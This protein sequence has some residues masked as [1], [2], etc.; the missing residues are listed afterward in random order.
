MSPDCVQ[1]VS[2]ALVTMEGL[3][4]R[5]LGAYGNDFVPT[6]NIDQFA[7][8]GVLFENVLAA[9]G[10]RGNR[11]IPSRQAANPPPIFPWM[12]TLL[13][14]ESRHYLVTDDS[15]L[16]QLDDPNLVVIEIDVDIPTTTP[17][18]EWNTHLAKWFAQAGEVLGYLQPGEW[19][20]LHS[21]S[22]MRL[23]D[24]PLEWRQRMTA[25]GESTPFAGCEPLTIDSADDDTIWKARAAYA[26]QVAVLDRC[27]GAW[28]AHCNQWQE[29]NGPMLIGLG[30]ISGYPLGEH[31]VIGDATCI[32]YHESLHVPWIIQPSQP[33]Q[34]GTRLGHVTDPSG[35]VQ[36]AI[37]CCS[38]GLK[39][40]ME[41]QGALPNKKREIWIGEVAPI[42]M[43]RTH[44]WFF[45]ESEQCV[46]LFLKPD[47]RWDQNDVSSRCP[48]VVESFQ[49]LWSQLS[50]QPQR[51]AITLHHELPTELTTPP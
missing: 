16:A 13:R 30:S 42:R 4:A 47:D 19:I 21:N 48:Q 28:L 49:I 14:G 50:E 17:L 44:L 37:D 45:V 39:G 33:R 32:P 38:L 24:S 41:R 46:Q 8:T 36:F 9:I 2:A 35:V 31:R 51:G 20:W 26:A 7:S 6:P 34:H 15:E 40:A 18:D 27:W 1:M 11:L 12:E 43:M 23:W 29:S 25:D 3:S 22:L 5:Y 10:C